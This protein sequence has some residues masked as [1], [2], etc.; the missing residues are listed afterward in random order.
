MPGTDYGTQVGQSG[1]GQPEGVRT[2]M[3]QQD[4]ASAADMIVKRFPALS[5]MELRA[6][7]DEMFDPGAITQSERWL[8]E[9]EIER[10][11]PGKR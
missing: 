10:R 3:M 4:V 11:K 8:L 2:Q 6:Q 9:Q 7:I 1:Y 5:G